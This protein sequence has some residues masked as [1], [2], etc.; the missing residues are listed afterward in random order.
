MHL[1]SAAQVRGGGARSQP[2]YIRE[3]KSAYFVC[4]RSNENKI[5]WVGCSGGLR[6]LVAR[7]T[8]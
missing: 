7:V 3:G 1:G 2:G 4:V 5:S 8:F 6:F